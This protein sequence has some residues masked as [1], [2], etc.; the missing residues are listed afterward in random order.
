M[1]KASILSFLILVASCVLANTHIDTSEDNWI[2]GNMHQWNIHSAFA[3][4]NAIA[5]TRDKVF[6]LSNHSLFAVDKQSEEMVYYNRLTGLNGAVISTIGYNPTL[7]L[8]LVCYENGHLDIINSHDEVYN[9]PDLYL[10]QTTYSKIVNSIYMHGH[11]AYLA[12]D[13]GIIE[14]FLEDIFIC[15]NSIDLKPEY[16]KNQFILYA[17]SITEYIENSWQNTRT[18]F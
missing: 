5:V 7:N 15:K 4:I 12:M 17:N 8:L 10:K 9:I 6:A 1:K 14:L 11:T 2:Y 18:V 13:F 16:N 3:D